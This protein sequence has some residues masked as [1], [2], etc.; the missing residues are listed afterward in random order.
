MG[1]RDVILD[2]V[3]DIYV[4]RERPS[5]VF[6]HVGRILRQ[7]DIVLGN[8]EVALSTPKAY[9]RSEFRS[10]PQMVQALT[11]AGFNVV[12]LANNHIM[13]CGTEGIMETLDV[14]DQAK[15]AHFGAGANMKEAHKPAIIER[16]GTK[17]AFL[18]YSSVFIPDVYPAQKDRPGIA[19]VQLYTAYQPHR[20]VHD[21]PASPAKAIAIPEQAHLRLL[22]QDIAKARARADLVVV[23]WHWGVADS[24]VGVVDYQREMG[25][26]A[27]DAGA[28][29]VVGHHPHMLQGVEVY[30]GKAIFYGLG[31][32][33]FEKESPN[34]AKESIIV[35]CQIR[36]KRIRGISFLPV[37]TN[38]RLE[39]EAVVG[40]KGRAIFQLMQQLSVPFGTT[41][42]SSN[43]EMAISGVS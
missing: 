23:S 25:K 41:I 36:D 12:G 14:L 38:E 35:H 3:G 39:P 1:E 20:R 24:H 30:K 33:A 15:I 11:S 37:F 43:G 26:F 16:N 10:D 5:S 31:N 2:I 21:Q 34:F 9:Q 6:G 13:D 8:Q 7:A 32:F 27:L 40:Q 17:V 19:V 42:E 4:Q 22:R 18:G 28:D 29:L